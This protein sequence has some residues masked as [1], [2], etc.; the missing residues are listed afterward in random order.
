MTAEEQQGMIFN[1]MKIIPEKSNRY[2]ICKQLIKDLE[3][4]KWMIDANKSANRAGLKCVF[5]DMKFPS[6]T[7]AS[8]SLGI[9]KNDL[10]YD[11]QSG[12]FKHGVYLL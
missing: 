1:Y 3:L 10:K 4:E 9:S 5:K 2:L 6:I 12:K 7:A 8:I 11:I